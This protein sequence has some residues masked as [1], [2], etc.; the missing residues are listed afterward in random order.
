MAS[1]SL[2]PL[3][4]HGREDRFEVPNVDYYVYDT[5]YVILLKDKAQAATNAIAEVFPDSEI[6]EAMCAVHASIR[7]FSAHAAK[8]V[9]Y[10]HKNMMISDINHHFKVLGHI[11]F[12]AVCLRLMIEKWVQYLKEP[13]IARDW[14]ASWG[15]DFLTRVQNC[16]EHLCPLRCGIPTDNNALEAGNAAD[17]E[18]LVYKKSSLFEFVDQVSTKI[19]RPTS[20]NDTLFEGRLKTRSFT[21]MNTAVYNIKYFKAIL[22][23]ETLDY[24]GIPTYHHLQFK[25]TDVANDIPKG[26]FLVAG[27]FCMTELRKVKDVPEEVFQ[28]KEAAKKFLDCGTPDSWVNIY[29]GLVSDT[30]DMCTDPFMTFDLFCG[31]DKCFHIIRPI[32]PDDDG[33]VE[34]AIRY[35]CEWMSEINNFPM[36]SADDVVSKGR[37]GLVSCTCK[38]YL[39]YC[40]CKHTFAIL[41][42]R[43]IYLGFPPTMFPVPVNKRKRAGRPKNAVRGEALNKDG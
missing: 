9:E 10:G 42:R 43:K 15:K 29:K 7:W 33:P 41:K 6:H 19:I 28:D 21:K 24:K 11:N 22:Q 18:A 26:S 5:E 34:A 3:N 30:E 20:L 36:I 27:R 37:K 4:E 38:G 8:F 32:I 12:V 40:F 25:Y 23:A 31:W 1:A 16:Q 2:N 35:Y 14:F 13:T 17:K 39:H